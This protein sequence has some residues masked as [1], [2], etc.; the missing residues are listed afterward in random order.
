MRVLRHPAASGAR[1][2]A[3]TS[4]S[5]LAEV[6]ALGAQEIVLVAQ[7]LAS[8]G[9]DPSGRRRARAPARS[10]RWCEAVAEPGCRRVR[11]LYLYPCDL[12]DA[13][14]DAICATGVPYFDLSLQHVAKPLLRRMRRWGDG[15][16]FLRPHRRHPRGSSPM[17]PSARTSSS[18]TRV[19]PRPTTTSCSRSS[20]R[21]SSTGAASSPTPGGRHLRRRRSTARSPAG[22]DGRAPGRAARA[23][24]RHHR[25]PP[26][27][28]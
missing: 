10:C 16:R 26:R 23:A 27:R 13:L 25:R 22:A 4:Q 6:D 11:L 28:C 1:S 7:D 14:I 18:A 9:R 8:Y 17:P 19:R 20:R 3:A 21:L 15:D 2:A 12:T 24:G 5:I